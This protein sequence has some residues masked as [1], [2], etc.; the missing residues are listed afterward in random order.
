[1]NTLSETRDP[2]RREPWRLPLWLACIAF[3]AVA[4]FFLISEHLAHLL[5]VLPYLLLLSC[6]VIHLLMHR[7]HGTHGVHPTHGPHTGDERSES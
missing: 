2:G 3:L 4:G 7:G 1:M 5:G 6:P